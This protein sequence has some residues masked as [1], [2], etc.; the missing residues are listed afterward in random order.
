MAWLTSGHISIYIQLY[1][2][3]LQLVGMRTPAK[4]GL[5]G[6]DALQDRKRR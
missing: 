4:M 3:E 6:F 5:A 2:H 1:A